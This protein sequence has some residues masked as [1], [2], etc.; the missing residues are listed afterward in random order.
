[1]PAHAVSF[2]RLFLGRLLLSRARFRFA[3]YTQGIRTILSRQAHASGFYACRKNSHTK[4]SPLDSAHITCRLAATRKSA[5]VGHIRTWD[6]IPSREVAQHARPA[7]VC[8]K[9]RSALN[10]A[11][12]EIGFS[13][14]FVRACDSLDIVSTAIDRTPV[15]VTLGPGEAAEE[16]DRLVIDR[17]DHHLACGVNESHFPSF[18]NVRRPFSRLEPIRSASMSTQLSPCRDRIARLFSLCQRIP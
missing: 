7:V 11:F 13:W 15:I 8:P 2:H 1:M 3:E 18:K 14:A 17:L 4:R 9:L 6:T 10:L 5:G 12:E 16:Y